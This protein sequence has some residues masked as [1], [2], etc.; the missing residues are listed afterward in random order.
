M[1]TFFY[2]ETGSFNQTLI[3]SKF[4]KC[5]GLSGNGNVWTG[6]KIKRNG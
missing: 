2:G 6:I 4:W 1:K 3:S 5:N